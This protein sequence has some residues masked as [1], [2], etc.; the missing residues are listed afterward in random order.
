[1]YP[2]APLAN[3]R[4]PNAY[5]GR[6]ACVTTP[7]PSWSQD[8]REELRSHSIS[9]FGHACKLLQLV[10]GKVQFGRRHVF[11]QVSNR[12]CPWNRKD[13]W[14]AVEEPTQGHQCRRG[15]KLFANF[16][17]SSLGGS[18]RRPMLHRVGSQRSIRH[19]RYSFASAI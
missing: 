5:D 16:G 2:I 12:G 7:F 9:A 19:E 17:K 3:H 1:M 10:L 13:V 4:D 18:K 15:S 14:S 6:S 8:E 11:F